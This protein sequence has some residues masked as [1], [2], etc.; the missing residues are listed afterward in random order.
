MKMVCSMLCSWIYLIL[1]II[2]TPFFSDQWICGDVKCPAE[3]F[4]CKIRYKTDA[5]NRKIVY[6][7]FT[8]F[9]RNK[10]DLISAGDIIELSKEKGINIDIESMQDAISVYSTGYGYGGHESANGVVDVAKLYELKES[11]RRNVESVNKKPV[12]TN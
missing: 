3:T 9:D 4:G 8:C 12:R 11:F 6:Q 2:Y 1:L 7:S 10:T 5:K